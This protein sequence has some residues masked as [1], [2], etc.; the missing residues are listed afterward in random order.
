MKRF[1][2]VAAAACSS[3]TT[4]EYQICFVQRIGVCSN[5]SSRSTAALRSSRYRISTAGKGNFHVSGM[6]ERWTLSNKLNLQVDVTH[7]PDHVHG[8]C[9]YPFVFTSSEVDL[10]H[11][12]PIE[13]NLW[14]K[15]FL[16][17]RGG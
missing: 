6:L 3:S 17:A 9:P 11:G 2:A 1:S 14:R 8:F 5:R 4:G 15:F 10:S 7:S 16:C 12:N 13:E